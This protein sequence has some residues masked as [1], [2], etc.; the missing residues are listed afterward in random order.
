[1]TVS[2]RLFVPIDNR[3]KPKTVPPKTVPEVPI[4]TDKYPAV[5][6]G[7][8]FPYFKDET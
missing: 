8:S 5:L 7:I 4:F 1:M 3:F 2:H 6:I